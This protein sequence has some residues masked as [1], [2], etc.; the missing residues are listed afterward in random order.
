MQV[1]RSHFF[2]MF[3]LGVPSLGEFYPGIGQL[4]GVAAASQRWLH[5]KRAKVLPVQRKQRTQHP[6]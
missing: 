6:W 4:F 3:K 1:G 2:R 5:G